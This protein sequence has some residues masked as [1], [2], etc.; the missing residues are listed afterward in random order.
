MRF[1]NKLLFTFVVIILVITSCIKKYQD[2]DIQSDTQLIAP[3][4]Y[5]SFQLGEIIDGFD[6]DSI[7]SLGAENE[8]SFSYTDE[9][10]VKLWFQDLFDFPTQIQIEKQTQQLGNI[11]LKSYSFRDSVTIGDLKDR[12]P[13]NQILRNLQLNQNTFF[14]EITLGEES[15]DQLKFEITN[16]NFLEYGKFVTGKMKCT[17]RNDFPTSCKV[18]FRMSDLNGDFIENIDFGASTE[19][20]LLP[21]QTE[22][23]EIDLAGRLVNAP[24]FY[25]ITSLHLESTQNQVYLQSK[26]GLRLNVDLSELIISEGVLFSEEFK[27]TG[28]IQ[29][30]KTQISDTLKFSKVGLQKGFLTINISKTFKPEG[31]IL[32]HIP[33]IIDGNDYLKVSIPVKG[34]VNY[35]QKI[36]LSSYEIDLTNDLFDYNSLEFFYE[37]EN[38]NQNTALELYST[39]IITSSVNLSEL[40][41]NYIEGDFG[42]LKMDLSRNGI[43]VKPVL[44]DVIGGEVF[45]ENPVLTLIFKNPVGIPI[46]FEMQIDAYNLEGEKA[47]LINDPFLLEYPNSLDEVPETSELEFNSSNSAILDF[48]KLP[49]NDSMNFMASIELNPPGIQA[50]NTNF[51]SLIDPFQ[52]ALRFDVPLLLNGVFFNFTDTIPLDN[53]NLNELIETAE[54]IFRANNSI[55]LQV[56]LHV[57]PFD[58][59]TATKTGEELYVTILDAAQIDDFGNV[60]DTTF[61]ENSLFLSGDALDAISAANSLL[62]NVAFMSPNNGESPAKLKNEYGF[63]LKMILDI[64]PN[65]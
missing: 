49:P 51:V 44:C 23:I 46:L 45:G 50:Q 5:G 18:S 48:I 16:F 53:S 3:V 62:L 4:A 42:N 36:D 29:Q 31:N 47:T 7:F 56:D 17:F 21:Q 59:L 28:E 30:V 57:F 14:P 10:L 65:L 64:K 38:T 9:K 43:E 25:T 24:M 13:D 37:F 2:F 33:S 58:T 20:G 63:D 52:I 1:S 15:V 34:N 40:K 6:D 61:S 35:T 39:D 26:H 32:L 60:T 41:F 54:V 19:N 55:P 12:L 11:Q 27:Y 8:L 22:V